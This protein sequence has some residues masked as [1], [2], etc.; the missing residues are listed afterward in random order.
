MK[1]NARL[2]PSRILCFVL[3]VSL[4]VTAQSPKEPSATKP[5]SSTTSEAALPYRPSL[6]VKAMDKSIDPCVDFY[7]YSCGGWKNAKSKEIRERY[8]QH[9]QKMFALLGDPAETAKANAGLR[10]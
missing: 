8:V 6:D 2:L 10:Q 5:A 3:L 1:M 7:E 4:G 9:V